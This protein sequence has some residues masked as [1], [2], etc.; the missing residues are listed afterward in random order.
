MLASATVFDDIGW[1]DPHSGVSDNEINARIAQKY[2][3]AFVDQTTSE[4]R[5]HETQYG[6]SLDLPAALEHFYE[7]M[8]PVP[9]RPVLQLQRA[10]TLEK[11]R[12]RP[13]D[14]PPFAPTFQLLEQPE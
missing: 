7:Q 11:L 1:Y 12:G 5:S 3:Y 10:A 13:K 8:H 14:A 4:F 6:R 9:G 2:V